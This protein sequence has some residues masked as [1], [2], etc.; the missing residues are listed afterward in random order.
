M[1]A[2]LAQLSTLLQDRLSLYQPLLSL[3]G[4]LDLALAQI[5][6]RRLAQPIVSAEKEGYHYVEGEESDDEVVVEE[7]DDDGAIEDIDMRPNGVLGNE[8]EGSED[9]VSEDEDPLESGSDGP[10]PELDD[11]GDVDD[12]SDVSAD[13]ED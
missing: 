2:H 12:D 6:M 1:P 11:E 10:F 8:S 3:S 5:E 4:R 7:G 9:E 13:D